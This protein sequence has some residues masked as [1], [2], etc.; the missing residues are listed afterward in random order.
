MLASYK[1]KPALLLL[2]L[3]PQKKDAG[4]EASVL[5]FSYISSL[6][7]VLFSHGPGSVSKADITQ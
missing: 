3:L 6:R 5:S 1:L 2:F 7:A 4:G